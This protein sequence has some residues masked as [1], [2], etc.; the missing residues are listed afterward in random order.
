[1][2]FNHSYQPFVV[3][4]TFNNVGGDQTNITHN[5]VKVGVMLNFGCKSSNRRPAPVHRPQ[6]SHHRECPPFTSLPSP[7]SR[8]CSLDDILETMKLIHDTLH[9]PSGLYSFLDLQSQLLSL[10]QVLIHTSNAVQHYEETPLHQALVNTVYPELSRCHS[11]LLHLYTLM[12]HYRRGLL[13]TVI[14]HCWRRVFWW[15]GDELATVRT[16]LLA[17]QT[18]LNKF[19]LAFH[20]YASFVFQSD[21]GLLISYFLCHEELHGWIWEMRCEQGRYI[22]NSSPLL[23]GAVRTFWGVC[24]NTR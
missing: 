23:C 3:G 13:P 8:Q 19:S 14:H 9:D 4:S 10:C 6:L 1:M 21:R 12:H 20:S 11:L 7:Q 17:C 15:H 5:N 22:C 16:E 18:V 24:A 2:P